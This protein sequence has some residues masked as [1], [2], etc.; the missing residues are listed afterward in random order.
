VVP[1]PPA[2]GFF[3][4]VVVRVGVAGVLVAV[5]VGA[6]GAVLLGVDVGVGAVV[7]AVVVAMVATGWGSASSGSSLSSTAPIAPHTRN[8][9]M[10]GRAIQRARYLLGGVRPGGLW[11]GG[12]Y[13]TLAD[14]I[15]LIT[16]ANRHISRSMLASR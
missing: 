3:V 5:A 8:A 2:G 16:V 14:R 4:V 1:P 7:V 12:R 13:V 15:E 10:I 11:P 6:A 9:A